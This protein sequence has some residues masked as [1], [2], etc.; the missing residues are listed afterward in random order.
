MKGAHGSF[1]RF[2]LIMTH[3]DLALSLLY[4]GS[5]TPETGDPGIHEFEEHWRRI[6][7]PEPGVQ[8]SAPRDNGGVGFVASVAQCDDG[9]H[10]VDVHGEASHHAFVCKDVFVGISHLCPLTVLS[11]GYDRVNKL[12]EAGNSLLFYI[13]DLK[14]VFVGIEVFEFEAVDEI[15]AFVSPVGANDFPYPYAIDKTGRH[16]L[17][18]E[19]KQGYIDPY[20]SFYDIEKKFK[21]THEECG[22][23]Q[24]HS[25]K[26][27]L[28]R[29]V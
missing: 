1:F 15:V 19:K 26:T 2:V 29:Q 5:P 6:L 4:H 14:Y 13:G 25:L 3:R 23:H 17:M 11:G 28:S 12:N 7:A 18:L 22:I 10:L 8:K 21:L 16:Y 20:H 9:K 27:I 24:R